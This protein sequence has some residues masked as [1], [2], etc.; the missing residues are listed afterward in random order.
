MLVSGSGHGRSRAADQPG[1]LTVATRVIS[2]F[3]ISQV[4]PS[5]HGF[6][7]TTTSSTDLF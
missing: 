6:T 1:C 4:H 5:L 3:V 7:G 2:W